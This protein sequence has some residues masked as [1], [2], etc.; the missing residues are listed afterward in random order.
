VHRRW[1]TTTLRCPCGAALRAGWTGLPAPVP[2]PA[3]T[4]LSSSAWPTTGGTI[5]DRYRTGQSHGRALGDV[6]LLRVSAG[7]TTGPID[8]EV[9]CAGGRSRPC[10]G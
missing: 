10:T 6:P 5:G 3:G 1:P 4:I 2:L 8:L 9:G 7:P